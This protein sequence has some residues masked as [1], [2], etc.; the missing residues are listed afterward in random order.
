MSRRGAHGAHHVILA[1]GS[2]ARFWPVSRRDRPKQFFPLAGDAPLL[3][4]AWDRSAAMTDPDRIW[5]SAGR[6]H[7]EAMLRL[8]P[9]LAPDRFL[10]EPCARN[11][12]PAV[13][14]AAVALA[15]RD[16]EALM[17]V[18]P[19]DHVYARPEALA[20]ALDAACGAARSGRCL[21]TLGIRPSRPETGYGWIEPAADPESEE[22]AVAVARFIEKPAAA[23]A[24]RFFASGRFLWN[25][26]VFVWRVDAILAALRAHAPAIGAAMDRIASTLGTPRADRVLEEEFRAL[27]PI[28]IDHAV[29]EKASDVVVVPADPGWD[30]VG[31]WD[32]VAARE[33][34][35]PQADRVVIEGSRDCFVWSGDE[36][37][38]VVA[39]VG[40][41]DL[42]VVDTGDALLVCRRGASQA[43]RS[44][45][46]RLAECGRDDVI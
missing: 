35:A 33:D 16:P 4:Q 39:L 8:L 44:V 46:D 14:L 34:R 12:A 27:S 38:R 15:R 43:V 6:A 28:S 21:A 29:M 22:A 13:G 23:D 20:A 3:R 19:S 11:T 31:S 5:V 26:G 45:V 25:S 24:E 9:H 1:G 40:V 42:I 18:I 2:G 37:R 17:V 10:A 32:A 36:A 7:R 41:E 30:D